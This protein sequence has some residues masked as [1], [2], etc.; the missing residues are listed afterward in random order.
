MDVDL[1]D[2]FIPARVNFIVVLI[3][4]AMVLLSLLY[5]PHD[6][7]QVALEMSFVIV[8]TGSP[9]HFAIFIFIINRSFCSFTTNIKHHMCLS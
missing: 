1:V 3:K 8:Q 9:L 5:S 4:S 7:G 6:L 2:E